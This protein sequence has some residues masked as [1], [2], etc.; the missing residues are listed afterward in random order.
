[1]YKLP[2]TLGTHAR[3]LP[4]LAFVTIAVKPIHLCTQCSLC[5]SDKMK[6]QNLLPQAINYICWT[7][8]LLVCFNGCFGGA[9]NPL[10]TL[11]CHLREYS[12]N[13]SKPMVS[14][15]GEYM[16]CSDKV[17]VYS[18]WGRCDSY[19]VIL[20]YTELVLAYQTER[21]GMVIVTYETEFVLFLA[22][23]ENSV[24]PIG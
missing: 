11:G 10:T 4:P 8:A 12:Y 15:S 22:V 13:V 14:E 7:L 9:I 5:F 20:K 3:C 23:L 18:C 1:M 24:L 2:L 16:P 6:Q 19:E 17:T 21:A